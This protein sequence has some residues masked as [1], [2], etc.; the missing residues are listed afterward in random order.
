MTNY[1]NILLKKEE[2]I[3]TL[4]LNR[5]EKLNA[6][7]LGMVDEI[8]Q[9]IRDL[10][11]D[12]SIRAV[13][14]T[15]AGLGF[16]S[17]ADLS[18]DDFKITSPSAGLKMMRPATQ[19]VMA[20]RE[21]PKPVIA[22]VNGPAVGGGLS[23]ALAC[24]IIIASEKAVFG[25]P[26]VLRGLHPDFGVTYFLPRVVGAARASDLLLTG[27]IVDAAAADRMGL[28]SRVV[29]EG[30]LESAAI[31]LARVLTRGAPLAIGLTKVSINKALA[32]DLATTL[33]CE[34]RAQSILCVSEDFN[35]AMA[36]FM[37]KREPV[38]KGK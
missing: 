38:F 5:P 17:G 3:A 8:L 26:F 19:L 1:K 27:R 29:P 21:M 13:I 14:M 2:G 31:E 28:V 32:M 15:G 9:V 22:A 34:A 24:D 12:S 11:Q 4:T 25:A 30:Q 23:L 6:M 10:G 16:C 18:S 33:E 37:A 20:F 36:A 35:E 7:T